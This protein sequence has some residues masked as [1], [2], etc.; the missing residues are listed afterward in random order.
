VMHE[1]GHLGGIM[2]VLDS[3]QCGGWEILEILSR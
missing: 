3:D 1:E 2:G